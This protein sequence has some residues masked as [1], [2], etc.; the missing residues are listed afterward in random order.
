MYDLGSYFK[1]DLNRAIA[2][3]ENII[4]GE[5]FRITVLTERLVRLEYNENGIFED[6]PTELAWYRNFPKVN[7]RVEQDSN[8]LRIST[9]YFVLD[10][11]KEKNFSGGKVSPTSTFKPNSLT[12][13][14]ASLIKALVNKGF[15][16]SRS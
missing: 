14:S 9:R 15:K 7:F 13:F 11:L 3:N 6:R 5:K 1:F 4:K 8:N 12:T 2:N 16:I 10:Y